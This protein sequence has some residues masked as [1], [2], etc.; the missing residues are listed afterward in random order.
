M[1]ITNSLYVDNNETIYASSDMDAS[2]VAGGGKI[3]LITGLAEFGADLSGQSTV[4]VNSIKFKVSGYMDPDDTDFNKTSC[5]MI[6]GIIPEGSAT[7]STG[8]GRLHDYQDLKGWPLKGC[9]GYGR[10][11]R[12]K[13]VGM[14]TVNWQGYGSDFS[15]TKTF[16]PRKALLLS[17]LQSICFTV[18]NDASNGS[19]VMLL[20]SLEMQLK[21]GD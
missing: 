19:D 15:W 4:F 8:P 7:T 5:F 6:G 12:P 3:S 16:K 17:R 9:F 11:L 10:L 18:T 2:N 21:R 20:L 1:A 13:N 14:T